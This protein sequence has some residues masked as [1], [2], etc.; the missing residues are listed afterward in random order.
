MAFFI[1]KAGIQKMDAQLLG[2]LR[3]YDTR[4]EDQHVHVIVFDTLVR[5]VAVMTK[6]GTYAGDF[7]S[8]DGCA[9]AAAADENSAFG[10]AVHNAERKCFG[11]IRIVYRGSAVRP[12]VCHNMSVLA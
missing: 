9:H 10:F 7:V 2:Q 6:A 3:S 12:R 4:T 11:E 5:G 1:G 8:S